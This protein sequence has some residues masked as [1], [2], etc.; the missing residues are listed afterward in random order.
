MAVLCRV[1]LLFSF[2][3]ARTAAA[4]LGDEDQAPSV[5]QYRV[6][7]GALLDR[8]GT[9][10]RWQGLATAHPDLLYALEPFVLVVDSDPAKQPL[11]RLQAGSYPTVAAAQAVC[12][13]L[14][15]RAEDC[16]VVDADMAEGPRR[17]LRQDVQPVWPN[18]AQMVDP[19]ETSPPFTESAGARDPNMA[20]L[21]AKAGKPRESLEEPVIEFDIDN[22]PKTRHRLTPSVT[23]GSKVTLD[24]DLEKNY[25][26]DSDL[27]DDLSKLEPGWDVAF[28]FNPTPRIHGFLGLELSRA[29][30]RDDRDNTR[31]PTTEL[32]VEEAYVT[33]RDILDG[34]SLQVGRQDFEDERE[35]LYDEELDA[36]RLYYRTASLGVELS[37]SREEL[38]RKDLLNKD[39]ERIIN[40]YFLLGR[41][42]LGE[43]SELDGYVFVRD[44]R[45]SR[46]QDRVY[47]GV[48][49]IGEITSRLDYWLD[50]A[51]VK[52]SERANDLEGF[53][54]DVG[55]TYKFK[56]L[57][58]RPSL[59][60]GL[61]FGSGDS[62]RDD[63]RDRDFRQTG[64]EDNNAKFDGVTSFKYYGEVLDPELSNLAIFTAGVGARPIKK[65]SIDLVYHY[66]RQHHAD[67][68]INGSDLEIAPGG[69]KSD[70]GH[71]IDLVFGY[72]GIEDLKLDLILGAFVPGRAFARDADNAYRVGFEIGYG[73]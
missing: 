1:I 21:A 34:L 53:A 26:L 30:L 23:F 66:Y 44:D 43:G 50:A 11:H 48:Q 49:S 61:A 2:L 37:V 17:M 67:D 7:L 73:F 3:V 32:Q 12:D 4:G 59:T 15:A 31:R 38:V 27:A 63:D 20:E 56:K 35:W 13:R 64:L 9:K 60:L 51:L 10:T 8:G 62:D 57:P 58:W 14:K 22:P 69:E 19:P 36:V 33:V 16:L 45:S 29:F 5:K 25:D 24:F 71:G 72:R 54:F 46:R 18:Q 70:L 6:R 39:D 41:Y 40:N 68:D 47:V 42:A 52:G 55:A 65:G 28:S